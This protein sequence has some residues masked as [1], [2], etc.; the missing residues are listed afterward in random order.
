M[1]GQEETGNDLE[2]APKT[3]W[4]GIARESSFIIA[5]KSHGQAIWCILRD[6]WAEDFLNHSLFFHTFPFPLPS[7]IGLTWYAIKSLRYK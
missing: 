5:S 2:E 4:K 6:V 1:D 3:G 7:S